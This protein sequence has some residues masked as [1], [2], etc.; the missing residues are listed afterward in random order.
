MSPTQPFFLAKHHKVFFG[1]VVCV[2]VHWGANTRKDL[3]A[4]L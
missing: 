4:K 3:K 2:K 1:G